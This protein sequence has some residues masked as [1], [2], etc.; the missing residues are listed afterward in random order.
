M[1][2]SSVL[3]NESTE[4]EKMSM[5]AIGFAVRMRKRTVDSEDEPAPTSDGKRLR[6]SS[7]NE[8]A[9]KDRAII[10]M[11]SPDRATNDQLV[12]KGTP[13]EV[14]TSLEERIPVGGPSVE[15]IGEGSPLEVAAAP[16]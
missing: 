10:P 3:A 2:W 8:E 9:Q 11:D 6:R 16:A 4:E 7:P 15:K 12:S 1:D 5:L 14:N 13:S